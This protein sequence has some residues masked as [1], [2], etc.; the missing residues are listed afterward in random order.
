MSRFED[1]TAA[2]IAKE[3]EISPRT[4]EKHIEKAIKLLRIELQ[5][6]LPLSLLA[7]L[8]NQ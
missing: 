5:E 1:K 3:L 6:Y 2:Q 4:A 7:W 8:L